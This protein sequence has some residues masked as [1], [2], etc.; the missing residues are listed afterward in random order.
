MREQLARFLDPREVVVLTRDRV[1]EA[2]RRRRRARAHDARRR[3][4][5]VRRAVRARPHADRR[6][7][8]PARGVVTGTPTRIVRE[9]DRA[10]RVAG[11]GPNFPDHRLRRPDRGAGRRAPRATSPRRSCARCATTSGATRTASRCSQTSS[12]SSASA[13]RACH[14]AGGCPLPPLHHRANRPRRGDELELTV[15]RARL[16]R[17]RRRAPRGRLRRV[18]RRRGARR[19]R[20]RRRRQGQARLRRGARASRC[21][22]PRPTA[23]RR[24]A[25]HPGAPWQVL[26]YE[27]QLE[28]KQEQVDDALTRIGRLEGFE[29]EPIV[30]A[31]E[32]WRYRNKLE[33]SFGDRR[34]RRARVRLPRARPLGRDRP[35]RRLPARLRARQRRAR[36]GAR[37]CCAGRASAPGTAARSRASCATS[38]CARAGAPA[39]CRCASSPSPG[40]LDADALIEAVDADGLFW[41]QTAGLGESTAGRRDGAALRRARSC[42]SSSATCA[43]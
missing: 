40:K 19:P 33:Y 13:D 20:P 28:V 15:D 27:R 25:D 42:T 9:V 38:S 23:S 7:D 39:S 3:E 30:P 10:R 11:I 8:R 12:A 21:S 16:R 4:D 31:V 43:S 17:Q 18:R 26:P 1:Q 41:T 36:A 2:R 35:A 37:R 6:P 34:G 14:P 29:L 22:S 5:L 24:V 32:Q